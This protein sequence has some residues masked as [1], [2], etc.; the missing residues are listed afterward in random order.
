MAWTKAITVPAAA[1]MLTSMIVD[2]IVN[3]LNGIPATDGAA[4]DT[5]WTTPALTTWNQGTPSTQYRRQGN[6]VLLQGE[7]SGA[8]TSG[9][10]FILP[11]GYRPTI[12]KQFTSANS[13][14]VC[15]VQIA[16]NGTISV[17]FLTG[18]ALT[19]ASVDGINFTID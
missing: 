7:F 19:W 12:A 13:G 14:G 8:P 9:T 11:S 16:V 4:F 15:L 3:N 18:N 2:Q 17:T 1:S 6:L 10:L 5:G